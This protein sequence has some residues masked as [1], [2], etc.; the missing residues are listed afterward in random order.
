[1]S[2]FR[3]HEL[4]KLADE[5]VDRVLDESLGIREGIVMT[6][7]PAPYRRLDCDGRALLYIRSRPK[8]GAVRV[9]ISGL[10]IPPTPS[11]LGVPT[12]TG[13]AVLLRGIRDVRL[14]VELIRESVIA[15][16]ALQRRMRDAVLAA[17]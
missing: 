6:E 2:Y 14:A 12:A 11:G 4:D 17:A 1:M 3:S 8:K 15:T 16:R 13:A 9:D 7:G 10:W 5:L